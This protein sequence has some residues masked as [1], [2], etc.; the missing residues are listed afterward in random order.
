MCEGFR[1]SPFSRPG[2]W[3]R[4]PPGEGY[5]RGAWVAYTPSLSQ[6]D[7]SV[8]PGCLF[9]ISLPS[10]TPHATKGAMRKI[11][12]IPGCEK[13][14]KLKGRN[15]TGKPRYGRFCNVHAKFRLTDRKGDARYIQNKKCE[16]C[17]WD[18]A[19]CDRHRKNARAGYYRENVMVLCPN[20]HRLE[21]M[22]L[23]K[24]ESGPE[25]LT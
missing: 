20:C 22:G 8:I 14:S 2:P 10:S 16:A 5:G 17:G 7:F 24:I 3:G 12:A 21:S 9:V 18:K 19:P 6:P 11:C 15:R 23:L 1:E 25:I 13:P 4:V